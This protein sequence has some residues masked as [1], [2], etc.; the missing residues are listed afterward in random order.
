MQNTQAE[1]QETPQGKWGASKEIWKTI[2]HPMTPSAQDVDLLIMASSAHLA[3]TPEPRILVL[4]VT[5]ALILAPWPSAAKINAADFDP[6]MIEILWPSAASNASVTCA[7]W[8]SL[9][10]PDD[11]FDL[12]IGDCSFCALPSLDDYQPVL[13]ELARVKRSNAPMAFRFFVQPSPRLTLSGLPDIIGQSSL[14]HCSPSA[15][16]LLTAIAASEMDAVVR[17]D[18]VLRK[19][20]EQGIDKDTFF[21]Q[22]GLFGEERDRAIQTFLLPHQ[23]NFPSIAQIEKEF[24]AFGFTMTV[25]QTEDPAGNFWPTIH[26]A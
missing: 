16:R 12:V 18:H 25:Y 13:K 3:A 11:H 24:S 2:G 20:A 8:K 15:R 26:F 9:P 10:F 14:S 17:Y 22:V 7:D 1:D 4:G 19:I 5:P 21:K 23:L 6:A